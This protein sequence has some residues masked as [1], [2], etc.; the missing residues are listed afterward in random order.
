MNFVEP[1]NT[2]TLSNEMPAH[3]DAVEAM[4]A[5]AF[6]P[7]RFARSAF[8]LREGVPHE[9]GLSFVA[10]NEKGEMVGSVRLTK[11]RIG[12][13]T[14]ILL[15]PL[16]V[17][18]D[19]KCKGLG[20]L[21]MKTSMEAAKAEG[22]GLVILVGDLPYYERFGFVVVPHGKITLPAPVDRNRLL[23]CELFDGA[24]DS[25]MGEAERYL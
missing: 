24:A 9:P 12:D 23:M 7:G 19:Y 4:S 8:R 15:G 6:G 5:D 2:L 22:H 20:A 14:A 18:A 10:Q 1:I 13:Q 16:V 3:H 11:V 21:L 25:I 17:G